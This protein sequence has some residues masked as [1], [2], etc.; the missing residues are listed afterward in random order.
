M[1]NLLRDKVHYEFSSV[2]YIEPKTVA[3][4]Q[5]NPCVITFKRKD[6]EDEDTLH[7]WY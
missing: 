2:Y 1:Y 3:A 4:T 5:S 7:Q 6:L